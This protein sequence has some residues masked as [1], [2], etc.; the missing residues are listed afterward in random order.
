[1]SESMHACNFRIHSSITEYGWTNLTISGVAIPSIS[2]A[3]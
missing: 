1:M 2:G 3:A